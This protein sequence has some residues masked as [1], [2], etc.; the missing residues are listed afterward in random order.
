MCA[1]FRYTYRHNAA[2]HLEALIQARGSGTSGNLREC[3]ELA[4]T[5]AD[6]FG[7]HHSSIMSRPTVLRSTYSTTSQLLDERGDSM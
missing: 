7:L 1:A 4:P 6:S 3:F 2:R 5:V